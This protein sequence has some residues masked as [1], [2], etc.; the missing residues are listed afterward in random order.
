MHDLLA[1]I[2]P[3]P[4]IVGVF[5]MIDCRGLRQDLFIV[6]GLKDLPGGNRHIV[7]IVLPIQNDVIGV[8]ADLIAFPQFRRQ[9]AGA[10]CA[11]DYIAHILLPF[12]AGVRR[13]F[14]IVLIFFIVKQS[15]PL[16]KHRFPH[17]LTRLPAFH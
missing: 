14:H 11:Q 16:V 15:R 7:Q 10:I 17:L 1:G 6:I 9:V 8:T 12:F 13:I 4:K 5:K 3:F 2:H